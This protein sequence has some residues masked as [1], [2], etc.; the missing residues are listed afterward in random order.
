MQEYLPRELRD[1]IYEHAMG[2]TE[3]HNNNHTVSA[4]ESN[5]PARPEVVLT[6]SIQDFWG[7]LRRKNHIT[8][9]TR[10]KLVVLVQ[11]LHVRL[12]NRCGPHPRVL[13]K[14]CGKFLDP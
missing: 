5:N 10:R 2:P 7:I 12:R 11:D 13:Q 3:W 14:R 4:L 9:Q 6:G 8:R 1:M